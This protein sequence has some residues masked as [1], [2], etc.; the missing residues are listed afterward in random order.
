[1]RT[2]SVTAR[3]A[4]AIAA[5][6]VGLAISA[7][8]GAYVVWHTPAQVTRARLVRSVQDEVG[9]IAPDGRCARLE[10]RMWR[11]EVGDTGGSGGVSYRIEINR[12]N[13]CWQG[14]AEWISGRAPQSISGC[15]S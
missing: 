2:A 12:N 5:L 14:V 3:R 6:A 7:A 9:T 4:G 13:R 15:V 11:C 8:A 10:R 1:M